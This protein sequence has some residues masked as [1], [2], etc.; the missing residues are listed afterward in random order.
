MAHPQN[1]MAAMVVAGYA[2]LVLPQPLNALTGGYYQK[3][4]PRFNG[5]GDVTAE[6]HWN[7]YLS[8]A[9]N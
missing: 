4:L 8:Y 9:Y 7:T 3:Y 1:W 6:E 5:Q 2:L